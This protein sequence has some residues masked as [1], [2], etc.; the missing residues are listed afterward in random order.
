MTSLLPGL[1][2]IIAATLLPFVPHTGAPDCYA[3]LL[4]CQLMGW[5]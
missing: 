3:K 2:M 4:R 1:M 5:Y